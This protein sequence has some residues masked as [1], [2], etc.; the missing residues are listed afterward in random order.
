MLLRRCAAFLIN[1]RLR[2]KMSVLIG[3]AML[4]LV[5]STVMAIAGFGRIN[6][7]TDDLFTMDDLR[8]GVTRVRDST[9]L[10]Q[11]AAMQVRYDVATTSSAPDSVK[12]YQTQRAKLADAMAQFPTQGLSARGQANLKAL[13]EAATA[14]LKLTDEAVAVECFRFFRHA[15]LS[16]QLCDVCIA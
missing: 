13:Q 12:T 4:A 8:A 15:I 14:Y 3:L 1:L 5:A 9:T 11:Q 6:A 2:T 16:C 10:T 7:A